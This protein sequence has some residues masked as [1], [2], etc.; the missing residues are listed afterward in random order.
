MCRWKIHEVVMLSVG[1]E[2]TALLQMIKD[3]KLDI[4]INS[5]LQNVVM[6]DL[7]LSGK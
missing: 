3:G 7:N 4:D 5:F 1:S 6:A 2:H